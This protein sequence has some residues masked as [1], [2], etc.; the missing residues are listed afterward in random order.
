MSL[1]R[2]VSLYRWYRFLRSLLFWQA[3]WFLYFQN[4]LSAAEAILL[5]AVYDIATTAL[6]VPSGIMSDR[7]GRRITLILSAIASLS[8]TVLL[9]IGDSFTA[10]A[11]GQILLGGG[12]AFASGTG[13]SFLYETL[14]AQ[15][16]ADEIEHQELVTWRY[17]FTGLMVSAITGGLIGY[18]SLELTFWATAMAFGLMTL[19]VFAMA[20]PPRPQERP[21]HSQGFLRMDQLREALAMP[22]LRWLFALAVLMYGFSHIPF[23]FGQP[24]ILDALE[25]FGLGAETP[26][27][28]GAIT[29]VMMALSLLASLVAPGLRRRMGVAGLL[30]L[31]FA[32]QIGLAAMLAL[33]NSLFVVALLVLRMVPDAFSRP[34]LIARIQPLLHSESRAT[35]LSLQ[36]LV[37]RIVFASSLWVASLAA[38]RTGQM[39]HSELQ[40]VLSVYVAAGLI[41]IT[42]LALTARAVAQRDDADAAEPPGR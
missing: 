10:L 1:S 22:A 38:G 24:F 30:L 37:G 17:D 29:T 5:Y 13:E 28:S 35:Y 12:M 27:V 40:S 8:G 36:S 25:Q 32:M 2:N 7:L 31:A 11:L 41:F 20:E 23:V 21:T 19:L 39:S 42:V 18:A 4:K 26:L 14:D 16:R 6:E 33:S 9:A 15:G 34:F 3:V